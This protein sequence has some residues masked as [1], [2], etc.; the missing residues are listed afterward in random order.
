MKNKISEH[1]ILQA[2]SDYKIVK[3]VNGSSNPDVN[4]LTNTNDLLLKPKVL[5]PNTQDN[6]FISSLKISTSL[7]K[8]TT[9]LAWEGKF[10]DWL[11]SSGVIID[12]FGNDRIKGAPS[13][14]VKYGLELQYTS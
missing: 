4:E 1:P 6:S 7:H 8:G 14:V 9:N 3:A 10:K 2:L 5:L 13:K 12:M 11:V